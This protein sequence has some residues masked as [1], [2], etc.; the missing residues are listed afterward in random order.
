MMIIVYYKY[1]TTFWGVAAHFTTQT[2]IALL[3]N[4]QIML[5]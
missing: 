5:F 4:G 3:K 2:N 1:Y